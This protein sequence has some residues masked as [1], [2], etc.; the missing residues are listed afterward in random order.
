MNYIANTTESQ[1]LNITSRANLGSGDS[2]SVSITLT[3]E[4]G[5]DTTLSVDGLLTARGYYSTLTMNTSN[6]ELDLSS[7]TMYRISVSDNSG[8]IYRGK[9]LST[10]QA[11]STYSVYSTEFVQTASDPNND[12][13]ILE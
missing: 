4:N 8:V 2:T 1:D 5:E 10:E 13:I 9:V 7:E 3:P 12:F 11:T 6:E